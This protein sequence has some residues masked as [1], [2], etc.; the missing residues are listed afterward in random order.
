MSGNSAARAPRLLVLANGVPVRG[1]LSAR[2]TSTS[3]YGADR[4]AVSLSLAADP[5]M[6][7]AF[8]GGLGECALDVQVGFAGAGF[9]SLVQGLIDNVVIDAVVGVAHLEGRDRAAALIEARTQETFANR[10]SSEIATLL[11]GRHGLAADVQP[12]TTPVGRYWQL[13]HDHITL[14]QFCRASTEWDLLVGLAG[15]ESFDVWVR[16]ATLH[17]RPSQQDAMPG[18]VLRPRDTAFGPANVTAL[19][20]ERALTLARDIEVV[21]KSWNSKLAK[22]FTQSARASRGGSASQGL[23]EPVQRYS[24][25]VPDLLPDAALLLAQRKLAQLSRHERVIAAEM[26]GELLLDARML[27]GVEG[28]DS[29]FDQTYWIDEVSRSIDARHGFHQTVRARNASPGLEAL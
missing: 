19:R 4:F 17:F 21:V 24:F 18:A 10:T 9:T 6:A 20:L 2:V 22:G 28:T 3:H 7:A 12:T 26:P 27:V 8:W 14:D 15:R 25:V 11:A 1:A 29:A 13:E 23:R 5:A 16:G